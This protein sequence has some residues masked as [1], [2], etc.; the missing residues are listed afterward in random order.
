[1]RKRFEE[2]AVR[3]LPICSGSVFENPYLNPQKS[4]EIGEQRVWPLATKHS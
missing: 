4:A 3:L 1:M 2:S